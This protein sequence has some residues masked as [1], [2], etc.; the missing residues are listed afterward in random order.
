MATIEDSF[1]EHVNV[2]I[3]ISGPREQ[4]K[5][6]YED[7]LQTITDNHD[8]SGPIAEVYD[9]EDLT[10]TELEGLLAQRT[11]GK[12]DISIL[13]TELIERH[14]EDL[15]SWKAVA[16]TIGELH[17]QDMFGFAQRRQ[18]LLN[19]LFGSKSPEAYQ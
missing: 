5:N 11:Q 13:R 12:R 17:D 7:I 16:E 6:I 18:R 1:G 10:V 2:S 9:A 4:A 15:P 8:L 3:E 19:I 14:G